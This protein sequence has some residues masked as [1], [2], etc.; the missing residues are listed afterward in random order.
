MFQ[1]KVDVIGA[2]ESGLQ[3]DV[4]NRTKRDPVAAEIIARANDTSKT[5]DVVLT[6][7]KDTLL[8]EIAAKT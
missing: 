2:Q 4:F 1:I 8:I 5:I 6:I 3:K 7:S